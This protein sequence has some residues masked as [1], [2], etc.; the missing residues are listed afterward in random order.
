MAFD[1]EPGARFGGA[2]SLFDVQVAEILELREQTLDPRRVGVC[3]LCELAGGQP[4]GTWGVQQRQVRAREILVVG[5]R[6]S[7]HD[8]CDRA[9]VEWM[10]IVL[11][12]FWDALKQQVVA[13]GPVRSTR[14]LIEVTNEDVR[15]MLVCNRDFMLAW[16]AEVH[17]ECTLHVRHVDGDF[18]FMSLSEAFPHVHFE[19]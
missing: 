11:G 6:P 9:L 13:M 10:T 2:V 12:S 3:A 19:A 17:G 15:E 5:T 7:V 14:P 18:C 16:I 8:E 1:R 4:V